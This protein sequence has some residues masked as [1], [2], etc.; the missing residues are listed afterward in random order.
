MTG[1]EEIEQ[2]HDLTDPAADQGQCGPSVWGASAFELTEC[3]G[4]GDQDD[5]M[6]SALI[7]AAFEMFEAKFVFEVPVLLFDRPA[8]APRATGSRSVA[9]GARFNR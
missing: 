2:A 7:A 6:H 4:D 5:V 1:V 3:K 9:V 8:G